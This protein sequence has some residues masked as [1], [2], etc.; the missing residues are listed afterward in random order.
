M[1]EYFPFEIN[2]RITFPSET[3]YVELLVKNMVKE[4]N[5]V[6]E[7]GN[8][9]TRE[10]RDYKPGTIDFRKIGLSMDEAIQNAIEHGN[11]FDAEKTVMLSYKINNDGVEIY[12]EDQGSGFN[13][14]DV[15]DPTALENLLN[16]RGRGILF[17]KGMMDLVNY[18]ESGNGLKIKKCW[19]FNLEA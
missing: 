13:P 2:Y 17:M 10:L 8:K 16:P 1:E 4:L 9:I 3:K 11:K 15:P 6:W 12:I 18:N 14:E 7:L 19:N 5:D